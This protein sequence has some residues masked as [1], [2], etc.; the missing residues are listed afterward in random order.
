MILPGQVQKPNSVKN[1]KG[2]FEVKNGPEPGEIETI[3]KGTVVAL[4]GGGSMKRD[5]DAFIAIQEL[6][7]YIVSNGGVV[8]H[9]GESTGSMLAASEA[10]KE[11]SLGIVC[12]YHIQSEFGPKAM[13]K[14][15]FSRRM[16]LVTAPNVVVFPGGT[17]TLDEL[18][19]TI[20]WV[21]SSQKQKMT[22]PEVFIHTHWN[23]L[24][25]TIQGLLQ[26]NVVPHIHMF[27]TI[28]EIKDTFI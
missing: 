17:G 3:S 24:Y 27:T 10:A 13:V 12:P 16:T 25:G 6:T 11:Y 28:D 22:P 2:F 14:N 19:S 23:K 15:Y 8:I 18:I 7:K 5:D 20:G 21:K 4:C 9:G 26:E 1:E